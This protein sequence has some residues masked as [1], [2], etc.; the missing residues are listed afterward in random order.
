[1]KTTTFTLA[2]TGLVISASAIA[3]EVNEPRDASE[4]TP[5]VTI[6]SVSRTAQKRVQKQDA[7]QQENRAKA[8]ASNNEL[9]D[10]AFMPYINGLS[11]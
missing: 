2:I 3:H 5:I 11:E 4:Q 10:P 1:M 7:A 6:A 9:P 8:N